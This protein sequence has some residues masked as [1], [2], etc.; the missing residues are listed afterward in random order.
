VPVNVIRQV[1][2]S[3]VKVNLSKSGS[4]IITNELYIEEFPKSKSYFKRDN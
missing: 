3:L 2:L 4:I 1:L